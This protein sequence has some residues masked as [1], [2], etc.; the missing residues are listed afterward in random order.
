MGAGGKGHWT[1][2]LLLS[3]PANLSCLRNTYRLSLQIAGATS[4]SRAGNGQMARPDFS[5]EEQARA[6]PSAPDTHIIQTVRI[7]VNLSTT[8]QI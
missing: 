3:E 7:P 4:I 2:S 5:P 1:V 6:L 8:P